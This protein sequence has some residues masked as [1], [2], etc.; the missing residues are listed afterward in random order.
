MRV[1]KNVS[2]KPAAKTSGKSVITLTLNVAI[3]HAQYDVAN[4]Q[5][6]DFLKGQAEEL[7][8]TAPAGATVDYTVVNTVS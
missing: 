6:D 3:D 1:S 2:T 8:S 7:K 4:E 5:I